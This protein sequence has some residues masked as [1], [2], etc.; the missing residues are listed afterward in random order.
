M[1]QRSSRIFLEDIIQSADKI[2]RYTKG[3]EYDDFV[4]NEMVT[5][6]VLRNI[7]IIGEAAGN[8]PED[9]R[10]LY[11][12][13]PWRRIVGLRNIVIHAYFNVD[14]NIIWQIVTVNL[15]EIRDDIRS[16]LDNI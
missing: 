4:R 6:A 11:P 2:R 14:L 7:E 13:I 16:V 3:L 12:H 15:P 10:S 1:S 9:I 8:I 5:D